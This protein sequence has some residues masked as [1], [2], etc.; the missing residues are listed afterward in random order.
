M[1]ISNKLY[2]IRCPHCPSSNIPVDSEKQRELILQYIGDDYLDRYNEKT[3]N[4]K[5]IHSKGR[6]FHC[7]KTDC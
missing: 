5:V 3:N 1:L 6:I 7:P 2:K 4:L